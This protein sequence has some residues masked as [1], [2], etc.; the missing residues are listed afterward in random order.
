[1]TQ[2]FSFTDRGSE[3][4]YVQQWE[5][6]I[7]ETPRCRWTYTSG[8]GEDDVVVVMQTDFRLNPGQE[9]TKF[10]SIHL[11]TDGSAVILLN[12]HTCINM[13]DLLQDKRPTDHDVNHR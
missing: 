1:M 7:A 9:M 8:T 2:L 13:S 12:T 5:S 4:S 10:V 6:L 11:V 3:T